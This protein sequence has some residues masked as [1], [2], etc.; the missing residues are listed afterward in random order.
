ME[1]GDQKLMN[2]WFMT[3]NKERIKLL[4]E[5]LGGVQEGMQ[6]MEV[7]ITDKIQRLEET[8]AKL[9]EAFLSSRGSPSH[10]NYQQE[11]SRRTNRDT[12]ENIR[13]FSSKIAK[14]E[15]PRFLK[16]TRRNGSIERRI[17]GGSGFRKAFAEGQGS[18]LWEAFEDEVRARFGPPDSEDFDEALSRVRQ[19]GTL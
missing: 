18:I 13:P 12:G 17:N 3:I 2:L 19:T 10:N 1:K 7:G 5:K 11:G 15:F 9:S 16:M 8:I 4:E 14:L 6:R